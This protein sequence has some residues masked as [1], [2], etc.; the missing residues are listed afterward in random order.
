MASKVLAIDGC[1]LECAA[2][3]LRLAG[4]ERF[5]HLVLTELGMEKGKSPATEENID[6]VFGEC[7]RRIGC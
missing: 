5:E 6:A 7:V 3:M 4:V 1:G 2:K